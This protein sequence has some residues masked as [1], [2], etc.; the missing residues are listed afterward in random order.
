[1]ATDLKIDSGYV[2][3]ADGDLQTVV[4]YD[5]VVQHIKQRLQ[6]FL[7]EYP[8]DSTVGVDYIHLSDKGVSYITVENAIKKT[9]LATPH[10]FS[11][12]YFKMTVNARKRT[13]TITF[14][15]NGIDTIITV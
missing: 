12:D 11:L 14:K 15:C 2:V 6:T 4:G 10:V 13:S 5:Q 8:Y 9:I 3:C 1:M 7:G